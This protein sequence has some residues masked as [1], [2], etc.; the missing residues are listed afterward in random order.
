MDT[1]SLKKL[2]GRCRLTKAERIALTVMLERFVLVWFEFFFKFF[3]TMLFMG[4]VDMIIY[5]IGLPE[6]LLLFVCLTNIVTYIS[7]L[8]LLFVYLTNIIKIV[9][10]WDMK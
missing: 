10:G 5:F 1:H 9:T 8:L 7:I 4:A 3:L 6:H 2:T